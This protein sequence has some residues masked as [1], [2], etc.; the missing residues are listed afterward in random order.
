MQECAPAPNARYGLFARVTSERV[1]I[2]ELLRVAVG[3]AQH[4]YDL[5][6]RACPETA[7]L[8]LFKHHAPGILHRAFVAQ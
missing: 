2:F 4:E 5:L 7:Q 1:E 6:S 3:R 8:E